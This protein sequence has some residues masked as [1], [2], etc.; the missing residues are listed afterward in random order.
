MT[1][2]YGSS[3]LRSSAANE[4]A[5]NSVLSASPVRLLTMLYDRLMLDL[6]RA[7]AAQEKGEWA[8]AS[9]QLLHAQAILGEL[10]ASLKTDEWDGAE[11][12]K[13]LYAYVMTALIQANIG[14]SIDRTRECVELLEPIRTAWHEA[15]E[16][17]PAQ[18]ATTGTGTL[19]V[20]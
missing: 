1:L 14:R 5:R 9:E 19:G 18:P 16:S 12:L 4:Y 8:E 17:L 11:G 3:A 6:A 7:A 20:G 13:S 15:A 10:T 2:T